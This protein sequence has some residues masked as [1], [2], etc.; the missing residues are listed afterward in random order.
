MKCKMQNVNLKLDIGNS[1]GTKGV[2]R[3]KGTKAHRHRETLKSWMI[4]SRFVFRRR[5]RLTGEEN[6]SI[7]M[8]LCQSLTSVFYLSP[9][10]Y[11]NTGIGIQAAVCY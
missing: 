6:A 5:P 11:I 8:F 1:I 10:A 3:H 9:L 4:S 7:G 2:H